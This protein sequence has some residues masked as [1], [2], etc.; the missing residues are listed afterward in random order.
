[1]ACQQ[2]KARYHGRHIVMHSQA[3]QRF[4]DLGNSFANR[5]DAQPGHDLLTRFF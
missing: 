3:C 2:I 5:D 4:D 1:M